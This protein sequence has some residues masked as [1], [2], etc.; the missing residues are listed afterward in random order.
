MERSLWRWSIHTDLARNKETTK[1]WDDTHGACS[2]M[3][4]ELQFFSF[5]EAMLVVLSDY[6]SSIV[7]YITPIYIYIYIYMRLFSYCCMVRK[8]LS[9]QKHKANSSSQIFITHLLNWH[10]SL[11]AKTLLFFFVSWT[12]S[13][14]KP[15]STNR[16]GILLLEKCF[17]PRRLFAVAILLS[18]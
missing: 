13:P 4:C 10:A 2:P 11:W 18:L 5:R 15:C 14:C 8:T 17:K 6:C 7:R 1:R 16:V 12:W 9:Q 3:E